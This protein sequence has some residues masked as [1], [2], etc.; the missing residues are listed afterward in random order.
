VHSSTRDS[1]CAYRNKEWSKIQL[2]A[3]WND[4]IVMAPWALYEATGDVEILARLYK[5]MI[6][7][8]D[9]LPRHIKQ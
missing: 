3:I 5:S 2:C 7:Y 1:E 6:S 4:V 9:K 8:L